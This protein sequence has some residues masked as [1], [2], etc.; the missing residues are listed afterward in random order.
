MT[1]PVCGGKTK[2]TD[3]S[4]PDCESVRRRRKCVDCG[5]KFNTIEYEEEKGEDET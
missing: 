3:T 5:Y 2:V 4:Y 1:C